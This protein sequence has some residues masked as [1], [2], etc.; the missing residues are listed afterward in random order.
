MLTS[1]TVFFETSFETGPVVH[2]PTF[3]EFDSM[4]RICSSMEL[5]SSRLL[6][7]SLSTMLNISHFKKP[8]MR[9][10]KYIFRTTS[11]E[12]LKEK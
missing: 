6:T 11:L 10:C 2:G 12:S 8:L 9:T 4:P 1:A 5:V 7:S 3:F